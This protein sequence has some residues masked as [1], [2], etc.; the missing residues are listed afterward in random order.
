MLSMAATV[1]ATEGVGSLMT[2]CEKKV[3]FFSNVP[4]TGENDVK[5]SVME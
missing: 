4:N 3:T 5:E 2:F 1:P